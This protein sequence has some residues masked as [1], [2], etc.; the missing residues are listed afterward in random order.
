MDKRETLEF[1]HEEYEPVIDGSTYTYT[2]RGGGTMTV[3][4]VLPGGMYEVSTSGYVGEDSLLLMVAVERGYGID[5]YRAYG[6]NVTLRED[7]YNKGPCWVLYNINVEVGENITLSMTS[8]DEAPHVVAVVLKDT[9][10][11]SYVG[12]G[13]TKFNIVDED[14]REAGMINDFFTLKPGYTL[15]VPSGV[16]LGKVEGEYHYFTIENIS[17][18]TDTIYFTA[19]RG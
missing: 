9:I 12:D 1:V 5:N 17:R 3:E 4:N 16:T 14:G 10:G 11:A 2:L 15:Q 18:D 13:Y 8:G 19:V 6:G 7:N